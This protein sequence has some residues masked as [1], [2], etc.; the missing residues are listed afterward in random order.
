M[1]YVIY[2]RGEETA[3]MVG[4]L[5]TAIGAAGQ[6]TVIQM[7]AAVRAL[8]G[9]REWSLKRVKTAPRY[10]WQHND[11]LLV[12]ALADWKVN[13]VMV[14]QKGHLARI[15]D[16]R[17]LAL[18]Y[19]IEMNFMGGEMLANWLGL[20]IASLP[21]DLLTYLLERRGLALHWIEERMKCQI[22]FVIVNINPA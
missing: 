12:K 20:T 5:A 16:G 1:Y 2:R 7:E 17:H 14:V 6:M 9:V 11:V 22:D 10:E 8:E 18:L 3:K 13:S 21:T 19:L 4:D 15:F